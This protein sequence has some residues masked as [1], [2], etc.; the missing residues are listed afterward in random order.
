MSQFTRYRMSKR[1]T[2]TEDKKPPFGIRVKLQHRTGT[3]W[4]GWTANLNCMD[5]K[6]L[7]E[8][9]FYVADQ[10]SGRRIFFHEEVLAWME[11]KH[12][13]S[14]DCSMWISNCHVTDCDE[15]GFPLGYN[16]RCT[17]CG[18]M[19]A[20]SDSENPCPASTSVLS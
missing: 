17:F 20:E 6:G 2:K 5:Q 1:L 4:D 9:V 16:R 12:G 19:W 3:W 14:C 11:I 8:V 13:E 7:S 18:Q 10:G 15:F